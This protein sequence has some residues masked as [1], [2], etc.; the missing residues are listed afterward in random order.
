MIDHI[1]L[2]DERALK[3]NKIMRENFDRFIMS[4]KNNESNNKIRKK[5][6]LCFTNIR[7]NDG[8]KNYIYPHYCIG[9]VKYYR[10]KGWPIENKGDDCEKCMKIPFSKI[11]KTKKCFKDPCFNKFIYDS[12]KAHVMYFYPM[13]VIDALF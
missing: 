3:A 8:I 2:T 7:N 1:E 12:L 11:H 13:D 10:K 6:D 9:L 5:L 4:L